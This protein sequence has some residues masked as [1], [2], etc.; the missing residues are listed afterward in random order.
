MFNLNNTEVIAIEGIKTFIDTSPHNRSRISDLIQRCNLSEDKLTKGFRKQY[1]TTIYQYQL[2]KSM[3][4][5]QELLRKGES[6]KSAAIAVGYRNPGSFTRAYIKIFKYPPSL[7][8]IEF[9]SQ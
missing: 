3:E 9:L 7:S 4:Y 8:K 1:N 6:V 5:A 2:K